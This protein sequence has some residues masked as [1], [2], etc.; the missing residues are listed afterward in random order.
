MERLS[1]LI[2][3]LRVSRI[4]IPDTRL[5]H[6]FAMHVLDWQRVG[7]SA[8]HQ[9]QVDGIQLKG[10]RTPMMADDFIQNRNQLAEF[11]E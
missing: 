1:H 8:A 6:W 11:L 7:I 3:R 5:L 2:P 9:S 4:F 10:N